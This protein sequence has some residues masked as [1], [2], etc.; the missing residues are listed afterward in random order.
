VQLDEAA[1]WIRQS[2]TFA[3]GRDAAGIGFEFIDRSA[4]RPQATASPR[5]ALGRSRSRTLPGWS[6][7]THAAVGISRPEAGELSQEWGRPPTPPPSYPSG[8]AAPT[9]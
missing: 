8:P 9:R 6:L 1:A 2:V 4:C 5:A 3:G 7:Q